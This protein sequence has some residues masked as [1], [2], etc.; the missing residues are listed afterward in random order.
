MD[1]CRN[2]PR[3]CLI[4]FH[5][6]LFLAYPFLKEKIFI[7]LGDVKLDE[8]TFDLNFNFVIEK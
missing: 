7:D 3:N 4:F 2:G 5:T 1:I 6:E 8:F